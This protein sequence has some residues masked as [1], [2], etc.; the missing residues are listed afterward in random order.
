MADR[1]RRGRLAEAGFRATGAAARRY[2]DTEGRVGRRGAEVSYRAAFASATGTT[3][4]KASRKG[5]FNRTLDAARRI[6]D[7]A[8]DGKLSAAKVLTEPQERRL[9]DRTLKSLMRGHTF[10]SAL[11]RGTSYAKGGD[12]PPVERRTTYGKLLAVLHDDVSHPFGAP[13]SDR[14]YRR[15]AVLSPRAYARRF[16]PSSKKAKLLV[17]MGLRDADAQYDVGET[18]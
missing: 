14:V 2:I 17:A 11:S 5:K 8:A 6:R 1:K 9:A 18:P 12:V 7:A 3:L 4:E 13:E 15:R 10:K 16:G